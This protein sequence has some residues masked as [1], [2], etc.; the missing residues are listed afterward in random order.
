MHGGEEAQASQSE[1][2]DRSARA[3]GGVARDGSSMKNPT[4]RVG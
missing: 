4:K 1:F 2:A 3:I